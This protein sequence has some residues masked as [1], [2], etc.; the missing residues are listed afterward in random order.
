ML[1][2][3]ASAREEYE[4]I[5]SQSLVNRGLKKIPPPTS[6]HVYSPGDFVYVY[7][8]GLKQYTGPHMIAT[9]DQKSVRLHL[10]EKTGPRSFNISQIR[11]TNF[12]EHH[13]QQ[14]EELI[15]EFGI[16]FSEVIPTGD[17]REAFFDDAIRSEI[18]GLIEKG[19]FRITLEEELSEQKPN[20]IPSRFVLTIK[21]VDGKEIYKARFVL[22]GHKDRDKD[23]MV[24]S[25]NNLKQLSI[26]LLLALATILGF[27]IWDLDVKQAY[28]QSAS[29]L[30][31]SVF[32]KPNII[33]LQPNE[34]LQVI[35]P[36]Y[37]LTESGDYWAETNSKF[38]IH[39][40][41]MEHSTGDFSL[42]FR[43]IMD[44]LVSISGSYVDD[45]LQ[46][47][48]EAEKERLQK[49]FKEQFD[50]NLT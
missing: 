47:G 41:L 6:D 12:R 46:A 42:F 14:F 13:E 36:L 24:H 48:T 16:L 5:V 11:P 32:I 31:R 3:A 28:L 1:R 37:G 18:L 38:H 15:N 22:G 10:G 44:K 21:H 19:T 29:K 30:Q 33:D 26:K 20:I 9:V 25:S 17:P 43:T 4:K 39:N 8:E 23:S 45:I 27:D 2:A 34:L 50:I 49:E 40:L 7:R 35:K